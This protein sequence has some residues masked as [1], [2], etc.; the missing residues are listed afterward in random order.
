MPQGYYHIESYPEDAGWRTSGAEIGVCGTC[1]D[2][3]GIADSELV[4]RARAQHHGGS[5]NAWTAWA[6]KVIVF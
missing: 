2:A 5:S 1:L 3:R 6:D 4:E